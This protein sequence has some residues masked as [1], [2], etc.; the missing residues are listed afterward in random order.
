MKKYIEPTIK[1]KSI[2]L[3]SMIAG[4]VDGF[5]MN[6]SQMGNN[7]TDYSSG[8]RGGDFWSGVWS[9]GEE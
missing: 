3:Q 2:K 5:G 1:I 9:D 4:S 8:H 7:D 6:G